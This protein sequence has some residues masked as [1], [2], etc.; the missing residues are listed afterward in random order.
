[1][2]AALSVAVC[3]HQGGDTFLAPS[4]NEQVKKAE[5]ILVGPDFIPACFVFVEIEVLCEIDMNLEGLF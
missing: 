1:M 5:D 2:A 3:G 4:I